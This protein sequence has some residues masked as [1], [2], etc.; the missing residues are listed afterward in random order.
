M[1]G[2]TGA[3]VFLMELNEMGRA[4]SAEPYGGASSRAA[5]WYVR[6]GRT[7]FG[8]LL[9]ADSAAFLRAR[10]LWVR[11]VLVLAVFVVMLLASG[12]QPPLVQLGMIAI[13]VL[14]AV[15][16]L[17]AVARR[18]AIMPG[19]DMLLP[20][21]V[22]VVRLRRMALPTAALALWMAVLCALLVMLGA[23]DPSLISLGVLAG[24]GFG[25]SAVRGAYRVQPD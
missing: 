5:R 4:H 22:S 12:A 23:G 17:G 18:T 24:V 7:P 11:P 2:H 1:S 8:A 6:G 13:A 14:A 21:S 25:A 15:P 20:L 19:L 16:A 3:A 9:R 10:S